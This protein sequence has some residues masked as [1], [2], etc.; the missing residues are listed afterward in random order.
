M[1]ARSLTAGAIAAI[2]TAGC[3]FQRQHNAGVQVL[4]AG[5]FVDTNGPSGLFLP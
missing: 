5:G 1:I 3:L 4:N 2:A